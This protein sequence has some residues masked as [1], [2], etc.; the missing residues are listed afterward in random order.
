MDIPEEITD[1]EDFLE[2]ITILHIP[3]LPK[4]Y[5][6]R[7]D[8]FRIWNDTQ[9][10]QRFRLSKSTVRSIIDKVADDIRNITIQNHALTPDDMVFVTLRYLA[11]GSFLQTTQ[12]PYSVA[13]VEIQDR[14]RHRAVAI[15]SIAQESSASTSADLAET[16]ENLTIAETHRQP[17]SE[18]KE[19]CLGYSEDNNI[20]Q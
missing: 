13:T 3:R 12:N 14:Q 6:Q 9:F 8:N 2:L 10:L 7:P 11:T 17:R 4:T 5:K 1:D 19:K 18:V 15:T 20:V 16:Q